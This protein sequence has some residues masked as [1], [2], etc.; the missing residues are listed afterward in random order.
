MVKTTAIEPAREAGRVTIDRPEAG[1]YVAYYGRY[2]AAVPDGDLLALLRDQLAETEALL[3]EVG[4]SRG[5]YRYAPGKWSVKE[6]VSHVA[7]SERIFAYRML[8]I[9][10]GDRTPLPGFEQDDYVAPSAADGRALAE[11]AAELRSVRAATVTLLGG[12]PPEAL[13]RRGIANNDEVSVRAL[14]WII[15]GHE[16]HHAR[17]IRERYLPA[18]G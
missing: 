12:L 7:D 2:I 14:A 11:L 16:R 18:P 4:E 1:E 6:I 3:R 17:M 15:A 10:R 5:S 9:A 8:R 13:V